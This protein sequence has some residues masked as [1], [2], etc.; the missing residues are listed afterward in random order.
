MSGWA[1][2]PPTLVSFCFFTAQNIVRWTSIVPSTQNL[3]STIVKRLH[4][5]ICCYLFFPVFRSFTGTSIQSLYYS[6]KRFKSLSINISIINNKFFWNSSQENMFE[7]SFNH[8][9]SNHPSATYF[10][11][12]QCHFDSVSQDVAFRSCC[13]EVSKECDC[14]LELYDSHQTFPFPSHE[15][16]HMKNM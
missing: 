2:W 6:I 11:S 14:L 4:C 16:F 5:S 9:F 10:V 7:A 13:V 1:V 8:Y 3:L 15:A 12:T